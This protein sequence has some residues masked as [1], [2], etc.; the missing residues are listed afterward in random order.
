MNIEQD[1]PRLERDSL[2]IPL[3]PGSRDAEPKIAQGHQL[4]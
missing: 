4:E 1:Q 2:A 3:L